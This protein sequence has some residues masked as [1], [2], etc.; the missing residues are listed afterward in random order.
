MSNVKSALVRST[1]ATAATVLVTMG[2]VAPALADHDSGNGTPQDDHA[3]AAQDG[4]AA[5]A[6]EGQDGQAAPDS[7]EPQAD[8][9]EKPAQDKGAQDKGARGQGDQRGNGHTPVTVC[10]LLGNGSYHVLTFDDNAL[11]AHVNHGDIYPVPADGCPADSE[12]VA[13]PRFHGTPGHVRVTVCHVLGNGGYHEL[14]FDQHALRAHEA[15]GDLYPVPADGCP[16][17]TTQ[18]TLPGTTTGDDT[19][20]TTTTDSTT[21]QDTTTVESGTVVE[22]DTTTQDEAT[23]AGVEELATDAQPGDA[24]VLGVEAV[25]GVNRAAPVTGPMAGIL[26]QTGAGQL[27]LAAGAGLALV[28]G[29]AALVARRRTQGV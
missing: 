7:A 16:A 15:H 20:T 18:E 3:T 8:Q 12:D 23:V 9:G 19:T 14:T 25:R 11:K 1:A 2:G 17:G 22:D 24:Q 4:E 5:P 29:G 10:H 28:A 21:S 27:G 6:T 26:P 13:T